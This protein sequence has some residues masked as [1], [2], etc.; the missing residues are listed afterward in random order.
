MA[1]NELIA[2]FDKLYDLG[3][4][5]GPMFEQYFRNAAL[6]MME[7]V[8]SGSTILDLPSVLADDEYRAYKLSKTKNIMVKNFWEKQAQKAGGE[9]SLQ[10]MVPYITSKLTTFI[11]N[12]YLRPIIAQQKSAFNFDKAINEKK[13]ILVKLA[14]GQI[15][16]L[17]ASLLGMIIVSKILMATL[18]RASIAEDKRED[19]YLYIDE[20][21]NFLTDSIEVILSE[22]RK[23]R[24]NLI[25]AHQYIGQLVKNNDQKF[26][27]AIFGN[28]GTK[29]SFRIGVEDSEF[30][31]KE[32]APVFSENDFLNC[33]KYNCFVKLLIDNANPPAFNMKS[34]W[35]DE[36]AKPDYDKAEAIKELSRLKYGRD[37]AIIEKEIREKQTKI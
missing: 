16:D 8:A 27:N 11:A 30:L 33:P 7:D 18:A 9:A 29:V 20:F 37:R 34:F 15:G 21:Q 3:S 14:K 2:I 19:F 13:I 5:G 36:F 4:T 32:F 22:A 31:A 12:D 28:V 26:K 6:L 10:N 23:Y 25:I 1:V 35:Y 24:L 17:N